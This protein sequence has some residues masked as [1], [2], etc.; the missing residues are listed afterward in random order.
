ML[1]LSPD[2]RLGSALYQLCDL[3]EDIEASH[4]F[5]IYKIMHMMIVISAS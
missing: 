2:V 3:S 1:S 4:I 5:F